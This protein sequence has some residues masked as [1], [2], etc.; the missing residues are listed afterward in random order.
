MPWAHRGLRMPT[1]VPRRFSRFQTDWKSLRELIG[2]YGFDCGCT[3]RRV[4]AANSA[5]IRTATKLLGW[6][7]T[8][9]S[10]RSSSASESTAGQGSSPSRSNGVTIAN[11][12]MAPGPT[13][14]TSPS[15]LIWYPLPSTT[16]SSPSSLSSVP[17]PKSPS[18]SSPANGTL[19][20]NW[21]SSRALMTD[22]C[23]ILS[24]SGSVSPPVTG[25]SAKAGQTTTTATHQSSNGLMF[26]CRMGSS[27]FAPA[28]AVIND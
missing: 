11:G 12:I 13:S 23:V 19:P 24:R 6:P 7:T 20:S 28:P 9:S 21:P 10:R 17:S 22:T 25:C 3:L 15:L 1:N 26:E 4:I 27:L 8:P 2:R 18:A 5:L 16:T 14:T